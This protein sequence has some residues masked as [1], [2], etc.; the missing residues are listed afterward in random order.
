MGPTLLDRAS[1][2]GTTLTDISSIF[3]IRGAGYIVGGTIIGALS[4]YFK[5]HTHLLLCIAVLWSI[6]GRYIPFMIQCS[7]SCDV[8]YSAVGQSCDTASHTVH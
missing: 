2:I 3:F 5:D 7:M 4:D 1:Y 6:V 8:L